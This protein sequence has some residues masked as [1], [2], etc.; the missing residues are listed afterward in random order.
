[1]VTLQLGLLASI[2]ASNPGNY[3]LVFEAPSCPHC[4]AMQATVKRLR[5]AGLPVQ[6]INVERFPGLAQQ[7]QV[8]RVPSFLMIRN[9]QETDR[10]VGRSSFSK[11][12]QIM[13]TS[14]A[15]KR[16][17]SVRFQSPAHQSP[18]AVTQPAPLTV[19]L[20]DDI[21][22]NTTPP[23]TMNDSSTDSRAE[24]ADNNNS[25][26]T[27]ARQATVKIEVSD[28]GGS[29]IGTGTIIDSRTGEALI[30]T[31]G[32]LFRESGTTSEI[33]VTLYDQRKPEVT[34][35]TVLAFD[36]NRID[37]AFLVIHPSRPV[38]SVPV[39]Q[40]G[41]RL[42][43]QQ[44]VFS[45]GCEGGKL[46]QPRHGRVSALN[47]YLGPANTEVTGT[48]ADG[49]S[50][51]GLFDRRGRLTGICRA[52]DPAEQKGV[53]V[54]LPVIHEQLK[55]IGQSQ[56]TQPPY[57][58]PKDSAI[59]LTP[60]RADDLNNHTSHAT[61]HRELLCIIRH[62]G[63]ETNEQLMVIK[64]PSSELLTLLEKEALHLP[65][66][67]PARSAGSAQ[68]T[69]ESPRSNNVSNIPLP[70]ETIEDPFQRHRLPE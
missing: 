18:T 31:C 38:T 67:R 9:G 16:R 46:P 68:R 47:R 62:S 20:R 49:A 33:L 13:R 51:C 55:M 70:R 66:N 6:S 30:I 54:G 52:A 2:I 58:S 57:A 19:A 32:H 26:V 35:A 39:A 43:V 36:A 65:N 69:L 64:N 1:M 12:R 24:T 44:P 3:L 23:Q 48:P 50:G 59:A 53:F 8:R 4:Q 15:P 42:A 56:L 22:A 63:Q 21:E 37:V 10:I 17:S 61:P 28:S 34:P 41:F 27:R 45:V 25:P 11:L 60:A 29:S 7:H 14:H 40:H 5:D